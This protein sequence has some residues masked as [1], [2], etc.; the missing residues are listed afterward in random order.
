MQ[1]NKTTCIKYKL[2][3]INISTKYLQLIITKLLHNYCTPC[4]VI[5]SKRFLRNYNNM[6]HKSIYTIT[7]V[8]NYIKNNITSNS[9]TY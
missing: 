6:L 2:Y 4:N 3:E 8:C 5:I 9:S 1:Q 7:N